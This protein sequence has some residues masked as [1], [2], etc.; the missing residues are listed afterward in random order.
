MGQ[1]EAARKEGLFMVVGLLPDVCITPGA[2]NKPVPYNIAGTFEDGVMHHANVRFN[3]HPAMTMQS[4][5]MK[6]T[7][8][9]AGSGGGVKSG[10]NLAYCRPINGNPNFKINGFPVLYSNRTY[11]FMNCAGPKGPFNTLGKLIYLD[12]SGSVTS[13]QGGAAGSGDPPVSAETAAEKAFCSTPEVNAYLKKLAD[14][15]GIMDL[16]KMV[17]TLV[18]T[19]WSN[20]GAALGAL[21]GLAG[22]AGMKDLA[23]I[24]G[25]AS[26]AYNLSKTDF[27][28]PGA[29]LGAVTTIAGLGSSLGELT[30]PK[31]IKFEDM[32]SG[33]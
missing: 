33:I 14:S 21:G 26:K 29:L 25:F 8:N 28:N 15:N 13:G 24:A 22:M 3:G 4:C 20:P 16:V 6:V 31:E 27:S 5:I 11:M 23:K 9:E 18:N 12:R 1:L 32:A 30:G 10:V 17:P 2:D 19:D 7:G